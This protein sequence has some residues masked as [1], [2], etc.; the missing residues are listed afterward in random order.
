MK[1]IRRFKKSLPT[2]GIINLCSYIWLKQTFKHK[3]TSKNVE[4]KSPERQ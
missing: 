1:I 2:I 4:N 3:A